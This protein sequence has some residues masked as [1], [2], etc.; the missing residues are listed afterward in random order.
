MEANLE[1]T[2]TEGL[3]KDFQADVGTQLNEVK[4]IMIIMYE[5]A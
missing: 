2:P 4:E 1:M 3:D 5:N